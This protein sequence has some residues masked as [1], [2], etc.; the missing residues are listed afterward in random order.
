MPDSASLHA[1]CYQL[2]FYLRD[3]SKRTHYPVV[4]RQQV[5]DL[6]DVDR[7]DCQHGDPLFLTSTKSDS[8]VSFSSLNEH[9]LAL[10]G[11]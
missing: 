5:A 2:I 11:C 10:S 8:L 9:N 7:L 6:L 4:I 3:Y 1:L